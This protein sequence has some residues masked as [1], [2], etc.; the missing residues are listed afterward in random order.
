MMLAGAVNW[1]ET[2]WGAIAVPMAA[3]A[4]AA[5]V[6]V[7]GYRREQWTKRRDALRTL[8]SEALRAVSDYQELPYLI[9][10]RSKTSPMTAAELIARASDVQTRLDLHVARLQLESSELGEAYLH[11]VRT[12]RSEAGPQMTDAWRSPTIRSDKGV[13]L[14]LA[15]PRDATERARAACL[16]VMRAHLA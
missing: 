3:A 7:W 6:A 13:P 4:L 10:R 12:V 9:R 5:L 2:F 16:V 15:Y 14:G 11:L 8:F 1:H